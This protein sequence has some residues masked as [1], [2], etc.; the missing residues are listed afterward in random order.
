MEKAIASPAGEKGDWKSKIENAYA[1]G[2]TILPPNTSKVVLAS[3]LDL[4]FM[5]T[6]W[7]TEMVEVI[8]PTEVTSIAKKTGGTVDRFGPY[9]AVRTPHDA[10]VVHFNNNVFGVMVP[11]N[12]QAVG[13]WLSLSGDNKELKLSPYLYEAFHYAND[14]GTPLVMAIDL[15]NAVSEAEIRERMSENWK[16]GGFEGKAD[17]LAVAKVLSSIRGATL[18]LTLREKPFGKVKIDFGVD[19]AP[20]AP[21][22]KELFLHVL[23]HRGLSIDEFSDWKYEV[24]GKEVSLSGNFTSSGLR[25]ILSTFDRPPAFQA[26]EKKPEESTNTNPQSKEYLMG[27]ATLAYFKQLEDLLG[28]LR[29]KKSS[30]GGT[31]TTG[32]IAQWCNNY[33]RKINNLPL[34][35]VDPEMIT[36]GSNVSLTLTQAAQTL[37]GG[38]VKGKV[39]ALNVPTQ[40]NT[41]SQTN[42][43]GYGYRGGWFGGGMTPYGNTESVSVVNVAATQDERVK[44]KSKARS[45]SSLQARQIIGNIDQGTA[46]IR[47]KMVQK[48]QIEF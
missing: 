32:S 21:I 42:V 38:N 15:Q 16:I 43:Y 19:A 4:E 14:L 20:L 47:A 28:D 39:D 44:A 40:Y 2:L 5:T 48:Y 3:Q 22:A 8:E 7:Q 10:F 13:R 1:S 11:A 35:N 18:G 29:H 12:R 36:Y 41:Y 34:L 9:A 26:V 31:Y 37:N 17:A 46:E 6:V 45:E 30:L 33:A 27:H 23:D 24:K 25:R